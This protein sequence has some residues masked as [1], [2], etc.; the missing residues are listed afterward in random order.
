MNALR[1]YVVL[2][3]LCLAISAC[4]DVV[5]S[6]EMKIIEA[7]S[8]LM[9]YNGVTQAFN[10][11]G[12]VVGQVT[13]VGQ[14][15]MPSQT[16]TTQ[17]VPVMAAAPAAPPRPVYSRDCRAAKAVPRTPPC[18]P[19]AKTEMQTVVTTS[20][21][22]PGP[23]V[24]A[25][26]GGGGPSTGHSVAAAIPGALAGVAASAVAPGVKIAVNAVAKGGK[27]IQG[28]QQQGQETN[29]KLVGINENNNTNVLK[30]TTISGSSSSASGT[31]VGVAASN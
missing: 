2:A 14:A 13:L 1:N 4:G 28:G 22:Y 10:K 18:T 3:I 19:P 12:Q 8:S 5:K 17:Q 9:I 25:S 27:M 11:D 16:V 21:T 20:T 6:S 7:E 26:T 24:L 31:G 15:K 23:E 29:N 30:P